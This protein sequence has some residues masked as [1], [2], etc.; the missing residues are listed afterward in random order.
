M[1]NTPTHFTPLK[2]SERIHSLDIMRGIVLFGI[3]LMNINGFGLE[4]AYGDP[5]VSGG[6]TGWNLITWITTNMFFEGTMRAL[7]S[8]LFGVGMFIL[9]DRLEKKGA[10]IKGADIYFRRLIWLLIFGLIHGYLLLWTGEILYDYALMG[11]VIYSFRDFKPKNLLIL[12][13]ILFICGGVWY[14]ADYQRD[15][16]FMN[17]VELAQ[18]HKNE[19]KELTKELKE[20]DFKWQE[21]QY[22][23][24]PEGIAEF[25]ENMHKGYL[26]IVSFLAP[27]NRRT[28]QNWP[29][30]YDLWDVFTMML[31]GIALFRMNILSAE[32]SYSFYGF[33]ALVGYGVGLTTNYFE[34]NYIMDNNFSFLSFSKTNITYDLGRV[35]V[36]I[37]HVALIMIFCKLPL[38][39]W[40]K[41]GLSAVGKMALTNY[42][43]HSIICMIFFTGV[44]FSM[45]GKLQRY[46]LLYVVFSIWIFQLILSPIWL[47]Y[48][49]FGPLEWIWRNLS[50]GKKHKIKRLK[51][52]IETL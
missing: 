32:K 14:Y 7:F 11:F 12:A 23:R 4:G 41:L 39:N 25:N 21:M 35:G 2:L 9:L 5:T 29:Y 6:A 26:D 48:F 19:N 20:A 36:A 24:S 13:S 30:R 8:L 22:K 15:L 18:A 38:L 16:K 10:G 1:P 50:Y 42:I 45:F 31:I 44:G 27:E 3:L 51:P 37:G 49:Q 17:D 52:N 46:E 40:L 33:M 34:V 47:K 28:D 43:M